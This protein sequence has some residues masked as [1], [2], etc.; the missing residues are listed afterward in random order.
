FAYLGRGDAQNAVKEMETAVTF[1][2]ELALR[3]S[4]LA[5][6]YA[7][8]GQQD[9]AQAIVSSLEHPQQDQYISPAALAIAY[10]G[11]GERDKALTALE[12][13]Q[14]TAQIVAKV[15]SHPPV[16]A[17]HARLRED[18]RS[19]LMSWLERHGWD[20]IGAVVGHAP[21]L[22]F[23][24]TWLMSGQKVSRVALKKGSAC[25]L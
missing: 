10:T 7:A 24:V 16:E 6:I 11:L 3:R 13:A 17:V 12:R 22:G 1:D 5:Y 21:H 9:K 4:Q 18:E 15:Y 23:L 8:T 20:N 14:H 2:P 19:G 25:L